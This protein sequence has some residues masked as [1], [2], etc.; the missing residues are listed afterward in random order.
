L[1]R[2]VVID[3]DVL[4]AVKWCRENKGIKL[5]GTNPYNFMK[6]IVRGTG[7][8]RMWPQR[9]QDLGWTAIQKMG[10]GAIFEFVRYSPGQTEPFPSNFHYRPG[11]TPQHTIQSLSV[12]A[13]T[14][15]LGRDDETYLIQVAVKLAVVETH[16]AL[17]SPLAGQLSEIHHL[18]VGLKLRHTEID[19]M[20]LATLKTTDG[21]QSQEVLITAEAK[22]GGQR[23]LEEQIVRQVRGAFE[24]V[25]T[26]DCVLPVALT[27][28]DQGIYV[29][30]FER[31]QR[32]GLPAFSTL[33]SVAEGHYKLVPPIAGIGYSPPRSAK[34]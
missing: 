29:V 14:K 16:F 2:T 8:A 26:I 24:A 32:A 22:Q 31:V 23:I 33:R 4:E 21:D 18:Q 6:D 28:V 17:V 30:E 7:G 9:L 11:V 27:G 3:Q 19:T 34:R 13:V 1:K 12:P 20:F 10:G 15:K 5:K 25:P